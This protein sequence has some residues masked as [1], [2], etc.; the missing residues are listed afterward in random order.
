M[1]GLIFIAFEY[2]GPSYINDEEIITVDRSSLLKF[3]Q[4]KTKMINQTKLIQAFDGLPKDKKQKLIDAY[5]REQALY[6][7]SKALGLDKGDPIIKA[8][9]IQNLEFITQEYSEAVLKVTDEQLEKYYA[10]NNENYYIEAFV[11]FTH[12]FFDREK[13]GY[14]LAKDLAS[15]KLDELNSNKVSFSEGITHGDRFPFHVNYVERTPDFIASHFGETMAQKVFSI[16]LVTG[17]LDSQEWHGPLKSNYG[18]HLVMIS[19]RQQGRSPELTEVI[20]QVHQDAQRNQI[21]ENLD[22]TYQ[23]IIETYRVVISEKLKAKSE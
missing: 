8:R 1:G 3:M 12:V 4:R 11:T 18:Y 5:V 17:S 16:P 20:A 13:H 6:R 23:S 15:E 14:D 2:F 19:Q 10:N 7:E 21:R 22:K 9:A